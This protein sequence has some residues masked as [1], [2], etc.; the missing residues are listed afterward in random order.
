[1]LGAEEHREPAPRP[2]SLGL[3][4]NND[5]REHLR[6]PFQGHRLDVLV[7]GRRC[8]IRIRDLSCGGASGLC[9]EA[10]NVGAFVTICFGEDH[11]V[12]ARVRWVRLMNVGLSFACPLAPGF[13]RR[14][15]KGHGTFVTVRPRARMA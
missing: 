15:H 12:D 6:L 5:A 4:P 13:V 11:M 2:E 14:L 1:M 7:K 10:L 3:P 9:D 8:S